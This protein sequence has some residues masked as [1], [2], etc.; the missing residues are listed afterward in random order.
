MYYFTAVS[1]FLSI[2]PLTYA[3][4]PVAEL[5]AELREAPTQVDRIR[6]LND[7]QVSSN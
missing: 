4:A 6:A 1:L 2:I 3:Q 7:S 5:V